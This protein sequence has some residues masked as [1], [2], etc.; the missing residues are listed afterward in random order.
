MFANMVESMEYFMLLC[1]VNDSVKFV[2]VF[3]G[4]VNYGV[5]EWVGGPWPVI[6]HM[7]LLKL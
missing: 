5:L 6:M 7:C 4:G 3:A 1:N 2:L